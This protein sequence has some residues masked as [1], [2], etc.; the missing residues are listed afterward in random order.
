MLEAG[1][2]GDLSRASARNR[3][4]F[5]DPKFGRTGDLASD[6]FGNLLQRN[7]HSGILS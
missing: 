2:K 4:G 7:A 6:E 5:I 1:D 3:S